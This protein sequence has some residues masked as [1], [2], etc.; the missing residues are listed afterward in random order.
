MWA[1]VVAGRKQQPVQIVI[2]VPVATP[3]T[4]HELKAEVDKIVSVFT[5]NPFQSVSI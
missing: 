3:E 1:A 5:P 4:C 2:A